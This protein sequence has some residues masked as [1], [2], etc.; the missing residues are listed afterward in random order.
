M[1]SKKK[2]QQ[3]HVIRLTTVSLFNKG[4]ESTK[5]KWVDKY[6]CYKNIKDMWVAR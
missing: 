2:K 3:T 4:A 1:F 5:E 6:L